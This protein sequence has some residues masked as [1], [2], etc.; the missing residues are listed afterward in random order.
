MTSIIEIHGEF[1]YAKCDSGGRVVHQ[2]PEDNPEWDMESI[3]KFLQMEEIILMEDCWM[4]KRLRIDTAAY[5]L[6]LVCF[7]HNLLTSFPVYYHI[8]FDYNIT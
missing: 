1:C 5:T 3:I 7:N 8:L 2:M 6:V 4:P